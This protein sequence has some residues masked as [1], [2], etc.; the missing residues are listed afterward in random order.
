[1]SIL[2]YYSLVLGIIILLALANFVTLFWVMALQKRVQAAHVKAL[3]S[4][5][6]H[7]QTPMPV[8]APA[9]TQVQ[10]APPIAKLS[11][12][13]VKKLEEAAT[14][15]LGKEVAAT[16]RQFEADLSETFKGVN[17]K[18]EEMA[19]KV[20]QDELTKYQNAITEVR[21][22]SIETLSRI[23][24]SIEEENK[25]RA[26][27][28]SVA[29]EAEK[30]K[31]IEKFEQKI[32]DVV[33]GYLVEALGTNVDLGAQRGYILATIEAHKDDLKKAVS[34]GT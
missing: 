4:E 22:A 32:G 2:S 23:Q 13:D 7:P 34:D 31:V 17:G 24:A 12:E 1:M 16:S 28:M 25:R 6:P 18:V 3:N 8:P 11:A 33:S 5:P 20:I 27:D 29:V 14:A 21:Q 10:V 9:E 19:D 30:Q 26:E 15:D